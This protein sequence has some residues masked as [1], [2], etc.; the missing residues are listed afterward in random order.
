MKEQEKEAKLF[1]CEPVDWLWLPHSAR[2]AIGWFTLLMFSFS[3]FVPILM[4]LLLIPYTW[5]TAPISATIFTVAI[6]FSFLLP[7]KEWYS[8]NTLILLLL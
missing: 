8:N 1:P 6:T 3:F 2:R 7:P 4:I 5:Q